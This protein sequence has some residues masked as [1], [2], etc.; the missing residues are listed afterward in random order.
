MAK[1]GVRFTRACKHAPYRSEGGSQPRRDGAAKSRAPRAFWA[2]ARRMRKAV[3]KG[4]PC[5]ES[6]DNSPCQGRPG[7]ITPTAHSVRG[8]LGRESGD[9]HAVGVVAWVIVDR[10]RGDHPHKRHQ[11]QRDPQ[12]PAPP[13]GGYWPGI[14][15]AARKRTWPFLNARLSL[16]TK[17]H[18]SSPVANAVSPR[19][20]DMPARLLSVSARRRPTG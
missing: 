6:R 1:P 18:D 17:L 2:V 10:Q 16:R 7:A 20:N 13:S 5:P 4:E 14:A 19:G 15:E 3:G 12:W 8:C 11:Q 9:E